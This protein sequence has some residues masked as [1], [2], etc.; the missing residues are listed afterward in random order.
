MLDVP[1][2]INWN[3][4]GFQYA[5]SI[6]ED[7]VINNHSYRYIIYDAIPPETPVGHQ[8]G[9]DHYHN[10]DYIQFVCSPLNDGIIDLKEDSNQYYTIPFQYD[11]C[12]FVYYRP[13]DD[14]N[15][16]CGSGYAEISE[17]SGGRTYMNIVEDS[18]EN[19]LAGHTVM[20]ETNKIIDSK[21]DLYD[22][23]VGGDPVL[24]QD[25]KIR[26]IEDN[27]K[28]EFLPNYVDPEISDPIP[29]KTIKTRKIHLN[30]PW[31]KIDNYQKIN[32]VVRFTTWISGVKIV[33]G[34]YLITP[35]MYRAM[36]YRIYKEHRYAEYAEFYIPDP[37]SLTYDDDWMEWRAEICGE[38]SNLNNTGASME[39]SIIPV[40]I[41][42]DHYIMSG[43]SSIGSY[44]VTLSNDMSDYMHLK[45]GFVPGKSDILV[46]IKYNKTY[47]N[48]LEYLS[49]TYNINIP[50]DKLKIEY[51]LA[52]INPENEDTGI[53]TP[54]EAVVPDDSGEE[55]PVKSIESHIF[56]K[57]NLGIYDWSEYTPGM[58][59]VTTAVILNDEDVVTSIIS[60]PIP[61][62]PD[63][64]KFLIMTDLDSPEF[65]NTPIKLNTAKMLNYIIHAVNKINKNIIQVENVKEYKSN[66][67]KPVF[68]Q[69]HK[70]NNVIVH[71]AVTENICLNLNAYKSKVDFFYLKIEGIIF[72]E[73][74][75]NHNGVIFKVQGNLLPNKINEGVLYVLNKDKELVTTGEFQYIQ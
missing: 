41:E 62:T 5:I 33:L 64:F 23:P 72:P 69:S 43:K 42:E 15:S 58:Y 55:D 57:N 50:A 27:Y 11:T 48:I 9:L 68:F 21:L 36:A 40:E 74:G 18:A 46:E 73:I 26:L 16:K 60:D 19:S 37:W 67:I 49:E 71:P 59:L 4:Y 34:C 30:L 52:I 6:S 63:M 66:I 32:Y 54:E 53:L 44:N 65:E 2:N 31:F 56:R 7:R 45:T 61:L 70:I 17:V 39:I 3:N 75:R 47:S 12:R 25:M 35:D 14:W 20:V 8:H 22:C 28:D 38:P 24:I 29:S 13:D 10:I 51:I 1:I